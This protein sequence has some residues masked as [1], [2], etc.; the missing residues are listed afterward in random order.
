MTFAAAI[1]FVFCSTIR[2]LLLVICITL[3]KLFQ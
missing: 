3:R 2:D 1:K